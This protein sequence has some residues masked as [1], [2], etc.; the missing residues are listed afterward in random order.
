MSTYTHKHTRFYGA[1]TRLRHTHAVPHKRVRHRYNMPPHTARAVCVSL[2][3]PRLTTVGSDW[4][5]GR[6]SIHIIVM[7]PRCCRRRRRRRCR[8][9]RCGYWGVERGVF[10][11][12]REVCGCRCIFFVCVH[13][14]FNA[15]VRV[16]VLRHSA[17]RI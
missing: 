3:A 5:A 1:I 12:V 8:P 15:R 13:V 11:L 6:Q 9:R 14:L 10:M 17:A 4:L 7:S 2:D 16:S